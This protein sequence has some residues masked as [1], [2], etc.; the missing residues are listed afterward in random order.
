MK[1][2]VLGA[3]GQLGR[4][5]C[6]QLTGNVIPLTREQADLTHP[7]TVR[8]ALGAVRPEVVINCA[9]FN[10]VD[11]AETEPETAFA[12]N[13][14]GARD[15]V[16]VCRDLDCVLV[17][18]ST[19]YVFG[20]DASRC[21]PYLETDTPGPM[22]AYG[23]SKLAGEYFVRANW[24]KH[25]VIRSCGLYGVWGSGGKGGNFVET[26]LSL[27]RAG[28]RLRVVSDQ[29]CTPTYTA[30]LAS[31]VIPLITT[32]RY[33][34]YHLTNAESCSWYEFARTILELAAIPADL[35]PITSE[36][37]NAPAPR[38]S[39]SLLA[40]QAYQDL[41]FVPLRPWREALTAY[42]SERR[43]KAELL[44]AECLLRK[45]P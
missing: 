18:F 13:A 31:A 11:R 17:H 12:V 7:E 1:Y 5:L 27:A 2:A 21:T 29:R 24:A 20:L 3:N 16:L 23:T 8:Q 35:A 32:G 9:A 22:S 28:K 4:D 30:D 44:P 15:L 10:L 40:S 14:I 41:G 37:Y 6:A 36:V 25:F 34:L 38:P 43:Q 39:Y 19:D 42:L 45:N 33:G 26:M